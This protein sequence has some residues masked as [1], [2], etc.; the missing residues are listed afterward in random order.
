MKQLPLFLFVVPGVIAYCLSQSGKLE[1][2]S[3]DQA[4]PALVVALLPAGFRGLVVAGLLAALMSSLSS[5]FNSCSTLI[6]IDIYK[7]LHPGVSE[8]RLVLVGQTATV[9]LVGLGLLWIPLMQNISGTLY[10]YLQSVQGYISPPITAVF[11]LGLFW[12]RLNAQGAIASLAVGFVLG[13]GRLV[14]ELNKDSL[15]GFLYTFADINFMHV[16]IF[17]FLICA[18]VLVAVSLWFPPPSE[19]RVAG[20]T[21]SRAGNAELL[22]DSDP[23]KRKLDRTLSIVL[24]LIVAAVMVYFSG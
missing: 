4:L 10:Q 9:G 18:A 20:L 12:K 21:W 7:K 8:R 13:M 23:A 17:L 3:S 24:V 16:A 22:A 1:L 2:A 5:V 19:Q 6:T 11:L 15:S 14:A